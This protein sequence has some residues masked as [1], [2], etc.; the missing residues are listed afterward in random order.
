MSKYYIK[1]VTWNLWAIHLLEIMEDFAQSPACYGQQQSTGI[2]MLG[3]I[4]RHLNHFG[5]FIPNRE[6]LHQSIYLFFSNIF[7]FLYRHTLNGVIFEDSPELRRNF[8]FTKIWNERFGSIFE[9]PCLL[10]SFGK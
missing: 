6:D 8:F 1:L 10:F 5:D 2:P 4:L 3:M 9:N 7:E